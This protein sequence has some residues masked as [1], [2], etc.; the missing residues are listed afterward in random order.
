MNVNKTQGNPDMNIKKYQCRNNIEDDAH[1]LNSCELNHKLIT[2]RQNDHLVSK[3]A[4]ELKTNYSSTE[5]WIGRHWRLDLQLLKPDITMTIEG[6]CYIIEVTCPYETSLN[7]QRARNKFEKYK[8]L[9]KDL[10]QVNCNSWEVIS[11]VFDSLGTVD[12]N[13]NKSLNKLKLMKQKTALQM[14]VM[15][16]S[17][18]IIHNHL[19]REDF[20]KRKWCWKYIVYIL[21][22]KNDNH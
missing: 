15:K 17:V 11:L 13:T 18:N 7:Q 3:I 1:I 19:G 6:H 4:K 9:L 5:V 2:L 22:M 16:G 14:T 21:Y 20:K 12:S 8:P 10:A